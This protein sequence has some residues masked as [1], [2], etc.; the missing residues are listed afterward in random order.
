MWT[1]MSS[2]AI[3]V[4]I[5][6]AVATSA[7]DNPEWQQSALTEAASMLQAE[8]IYEEKG[9]ELANFLRNA[10]AGYAGIEDQREFASRVTA[11]LY[12]ITSDAHLRLMYDPEETHADTPARTRDPERA[13]RMER[14]RSA[15]MEWRV[16]DGNVGYVQIPR[17]RG[18]DAYR[19]QFDAAMAD[20]ADT[21]GMVLDVRDNCGGEPTTLLHISSYFF[22]EPTHLTSTERRGADTGERWTHDDVAGERYVDRP[23]AI[24]TN[25]HSFSAAESFAFGMKVSGRAVTVGERTG[26]GGY[27]G[28]VARLTPDYTMFVPVG[29]TFD[30]RTGEGWEATGVEPDVEASSDGALEAALTYLSSEAG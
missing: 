13:A 14:C 12:E 7:I 8:Y 27:F 15:S 18:D 16:L 4:S 21:E 6:S 17:M 20:L 3:G 28:G 23:V 1:W 10:G 19:A 29:R 30:P 2:A 22:A 24:L 5:A 26:G 11:D 25:M 9:N